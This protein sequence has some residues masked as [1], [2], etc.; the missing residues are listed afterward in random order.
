MLHHLVLKLHRRLPEPP[1]IPDWVRFIVD[2]SVQVTSVD[3]DVDRVLRD[4]GRSFW[5]THE[6]SPAEEGA[7]G[8]VEVHHGLDRTY[9]IVFRDRSAEPLGPAVLARLVALPS[10]ESAHELEVAGAPL[11]E[12]PAL[13]S[14]ASRRDTATSDLIGLGYA[15]AVTRGRRDVL[16]AVLDTGIDPHHPE[17][18]GRIAGGADF[19]DLAGL[20]T[21]EFVGDYLGLDDDYTDELGHGT[22][23]AAIIAGAG[24]GMDEG[25]APGVA[26][27][28]VRVLATLRDGSGLQG[29][30]IVDNI[31]RGI[32]WAV[33][34]GADVIN[35]SLGIRHTGGGLPHDDVI[36]YA[37]SRGVTVVAASGN[38]GTATKYYPGALPG[39]IAVGAADDTGRVADFSSWGA[40]ITVIAPGVN[41]VSAFANG[42]YAVASGTSQAAP[43]VTGAVALLKSAALDRSARLGPDRV[44]QILRETSD[45][46]DSRPR[47]PQA[48][49]GLINLTDAFKWLLHSL[50]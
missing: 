2:K 37:L 40:P 32:K 17:M 16:V 29:A 19:V 31:N 4:A 20:D 47:S 5:V 44:E 34:Q 22:H 13:A 38:D 41:V 36:R 21:S 27:L 6:Y 26:V 39:V 35:M 12:P 24:I 48:G 9:R 15:R 49:Y 46:I 42:R 30:G 33:D 14:A 11:P 50:N 18:R 43:Y 45:R 23:V 25:V 1:V 10:V 7:W 3:P 8:A 28:A